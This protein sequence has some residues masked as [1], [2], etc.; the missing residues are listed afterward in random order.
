MRPASWIQANRSIPVER[1]HYLARHG[2]DVELGFGNKIRDSSG[3]VAGSLQDLRVIAEQRR[4]VS[5]RIQPCRDFVK[6]R[7]EGGDH[8]GAGQ[9]RSGGF[10]P[11]DHGGLR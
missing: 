3:G 7:F 1:W 11:C 8:R 6:M 2:L 5:L 10:T 4:D 9:G